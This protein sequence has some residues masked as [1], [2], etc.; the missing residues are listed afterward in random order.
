MKCLTLC[1]HKPQCKYRLPL[2]HSGERENPLH[3]T[4]L[5]LL[6]KACC[7]AYLLLIRRKEDQSS[8]T[9]PWI[10]RCGLVSVAQGK[11]RHEMYSTH[12]PG[13]AA[14]NA[15]PVPPGV[16]AAFY[17]PAGAAPAVPVPHLDAPNGLQARPEHSQCCKHGA[18]KPTGIHPLSKLGKCLA[19]ARGRC[20][21]CRRGCPHFWL[22]HVSCWLFGVTPACWC[23]ATAR[24][25]RRAGRQGCHHV[26]D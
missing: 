4:Q 5:W 16:R 3:Q 15:F 19:T 9:C 12:T 22:R 7:V 21:V 11:P 14:C 20:R 6:S 8:C 23:L 25:G 2:Q 26:S 18:P 17:A 13:H 24:G 10:N 1:K